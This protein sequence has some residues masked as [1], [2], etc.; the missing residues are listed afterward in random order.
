MRNFTVP[1]PHRSL[2]TFLVWHW[3]KK[4]I[5]NCITAAAFPL[6]RELC[7]QLVMFA[8]LDW[9]KVQTEFHSS[10]WVNTQH[11]SACMGET[12]MQKATQ[13]ARRGNERLLVESARGWTVGKSSTANYLVDHLYH[14]NLWIMLCLRLQPEPQCCWYSNTTLKHSTDT[15]YK[16][17]CCFDK[18]KPA[19]AFKNHLTGQPCLYP[20]SSAGIAVLVRNDTYLYADWHG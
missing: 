8:H 15:T 7:F 18:T 17:V 14:F 4:I 10:N 3:K 1:L 12:S 9:K 11:A 19:T 13:R 16:A 5:R 20:D 6:D 2:Q